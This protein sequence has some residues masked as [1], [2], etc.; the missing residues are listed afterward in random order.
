MKIE[1]LAVAVIDACTIVEVDHMITG[2]FAF[3]LYGIPRTTSDVDL[4]LSVKQTD[5]IERVV[6]QLSPM[7]VQKLRWGRNKNLD[8]ARD[9]LAVQN[10]TNLDMEYIRHWCAEHKTIDLLRDALASIPPQ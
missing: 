3:N 7:V 1:E 6:K 9:V 8:D 4:V 10:P 2:A 5:A